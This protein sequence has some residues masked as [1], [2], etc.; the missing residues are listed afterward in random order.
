[1]VNTPARG[2]TFVIE[3]GLRVV[4]VSSSISDPN[5]HS[6]PYYKPPSTETYQTEDVTYS[7][8]AEP[9]MTIEDEVDWE[10]KHEIITT[11]T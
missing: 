10:R 9:A 2:K 8:D 6:A 11:P 1:M 7:S 3:A 4:P 5:F